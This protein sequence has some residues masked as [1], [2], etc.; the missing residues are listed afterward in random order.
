M[1]RWEKSLFPPPTLYDITNHTIQGGPLLPSAVEGVSSA[2]TYCAVVCCLLAM[3][4]QELNN[5]SLDQ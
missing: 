3:V 2:A 5:K 1:G 4:S